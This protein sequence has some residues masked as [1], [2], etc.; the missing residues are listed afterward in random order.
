[1]ELA[2]EFNRAADEAEPARRSITHGI[3]RAMA[4]SLR[5]RR[6][7]SSLHGNERATET[8][9]RPFAES[10]R[11]SQAPAPPGKR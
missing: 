6:L 5:G 4:R 1:M 7:G 2:Q 11:S 10:S 8:Q 9:P 3:V